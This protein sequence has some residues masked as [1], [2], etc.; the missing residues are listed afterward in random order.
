MEDYAG[1]I[2]D[3]CKKTLKTEDG[4][5]A[6]NFQDENGALDQKYA[7]IDCML[8]AMK[9]NEGKKWYGR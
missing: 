2:C 3:G 5:A 4:G 7:H 9:N 6:F 8:D 1:Q